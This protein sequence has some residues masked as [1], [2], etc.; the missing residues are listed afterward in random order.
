VFVFFDP[1]VT[2]GISI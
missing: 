2:V 1:E